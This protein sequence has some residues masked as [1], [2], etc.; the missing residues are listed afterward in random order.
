MRFLRVSAS[1]AA[2]LLCAVLIQGLLGLRAAPR[3][4]VDPAANGDV[5][6]DGRIDISDA[7]HT[8][9]Y[10]FQ[11]GPAPCA[12]QAA[13][14]CCPAQIEQL[15][16][17]TAEL[18]KVSESIDRLGSPRPRDVVNIVVTDLSIP[19]AGISPV[20]A[21]PIGKRLVV[22]DVRSYENNQVGTDL[23]D[24]VEVSG[25]DEVVKMPSFFV[26]I[27]GAGGAEGFSGRTPIV[28]S[29]GS[30]LALRDRP[31]QNN[32]QTTIYRLYIMGYLVDA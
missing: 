23:F 11:D 31:D 17:L 32:A 21:T 20:Y 19:S 26:S 15:A 29:P 12:A 9:V 30:A 8:L 6:C 3:G 14:S 16:S 7:V 25:E 28:F 5:N 18:K 1:V 10:L 27:G 4:G 24:I 13:D 2:V 22:T